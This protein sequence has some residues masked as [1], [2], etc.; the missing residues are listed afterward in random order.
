MTPG[1]TGDGLL[2]ALA[3]LAILAVAL[4]SLLDVEQQ[5]ARSARQRLGMI[6]T[7]DLERSA[8]VLLRDLNPE[9]EP[10]GGA[11]LGPASRLVW[12]STPLSAFHP[13]TNGLTG[14]GAFE[15]RLYRVDARILDAQGRQVT[16]FRIDRPGW[17]RTAAVR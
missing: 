11:S 4:A 13:N 1:K 5:F 16:R 10:Q 15:V 8:L 9:S 7:A 12:T 3:A 2:E 14:V 6:A 17:R